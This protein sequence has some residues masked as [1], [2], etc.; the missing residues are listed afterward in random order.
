VDKIDQGVIRLVVDTA[1]NELFPDQRHALP[2]NLF[3]ALGQIDVANFDRAG[4]A[5]GNGIVR[6]I[7]KPVA[8]FQPV[9]DTTFEIGDVTRHPTDF[10]IGDCL[11]DNVV[12]DPVDPD[13]A[14]DFGMRDCHR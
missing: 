5:A 10:G 8:I 2:K 7:F 9:Y 4:L 12:A 1:D 13:L 11:D 3:T 6:R 14:N